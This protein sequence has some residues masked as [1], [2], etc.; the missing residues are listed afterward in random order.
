MVTVVPTILLY[1]V[2][3]E[4]VSIVNSVTYQSIEVVGLSVT[5]PT[6]I[7]WIAPV[8]NTEGPP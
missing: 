1:V 2:E 8:R 4:V 5:Y 6:T 3:V 7:V